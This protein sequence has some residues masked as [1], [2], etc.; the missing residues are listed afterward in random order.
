MQLFLQL[1]SFSFFFFLFPFEMRYD[2]LVY[3]Q[4]IQYFMFLPIKQQYFQRWYPKLQW[5]GGWVCVGNPR[6][7]F[8]PSHHPRKNSQSL[9]PES[10]HRPTVTHGRAG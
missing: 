1:L 3:L 9:A 8:P 2:R 5:V 6:I 7:K 4:K 10:R